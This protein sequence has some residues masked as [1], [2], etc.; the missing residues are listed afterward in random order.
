MTTATKKE[1]TVYVTSFSSPEMYTKIE[2][3]FDSFGGK[4]LVK[5][6]E[7]GVFDVMSNEYGR[8]MFEITFLHS[9]VIFLI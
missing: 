4:F 9:S 6:K 1:L 7:D 3:T 5:K 8:N 2:K